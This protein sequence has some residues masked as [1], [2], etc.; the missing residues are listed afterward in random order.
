MEQSTAPVTL[1]VVGTAIVPATTPTVVGSPVV[2][3]LIA[4]NSALNVAA[5]AQSAYLTSKIFSKIGYEFA[6]NDY[7]PY[8]GVMGEFEFS[9]C[10]NNALP[11]WSV[12]LVGGVSF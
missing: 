9:N 11:Q 3:N 2:G 8:I 6:H 12:A 10:L 7:V 5:A 1:A 4:G